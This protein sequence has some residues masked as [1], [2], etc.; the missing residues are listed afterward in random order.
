MK[1]LHVVLSIVFWIFIFRSNKPIIQNMYCMHKNTFYY[2]Y[3]DLTK[4]KWK[5]FVIRLLSKIN[6]I[7]NWDIVLYTLSSK[8]LMIAKKSTNVHFLLFSFGVITNLLNLAIIRCLNFSVFIDNWFLHFC[9]L[10]F[11]L[12][13]LGT[14]YF[15]RRL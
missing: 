4:V 10:V 15:T 2:M 7:L 14:L 1:T 3:I 5:N 8:V 13:L 6:K 12:Y 9:S 11:F